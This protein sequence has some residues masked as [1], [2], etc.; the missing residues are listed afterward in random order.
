MKM[1]PRGF[2]LLEVLITLV[3]LAFG[4]LGLANL[5]AKMHTAEMESYQRAQAVLLV[6]DMINRIMANR[7]NAATYV[8]TYAGVGADCSGV[9]AG[10]A[11]DQCDWQ[12][13]L[14]GAAETAGG[15]NVGAMIGAQG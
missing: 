12:S 1:N 6:D 15:S 8:G 5:Q 7:A 9:A 2:T 3:V 4:I 10:L 13:G 11:R 14:A